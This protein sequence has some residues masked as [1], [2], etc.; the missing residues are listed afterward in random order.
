MSLVS[1]RYS[2]CEAVNA[3]P[4]PCNCSGTRY[5]K[6]KYALLYVPFAPVPLSGVMAAPGSAVC[7]GHV[8]DESEPGVEEFWPVEEILSAPIMNSAPA[9]MSDRPSNPANEP[10]MIRECSTDA[11]GRDGAADM[12]HLTS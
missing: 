12:R 7:P 4:P 8:G 1:S 5:E 9:T 2:F 3:F 11:V 6:L 10:R